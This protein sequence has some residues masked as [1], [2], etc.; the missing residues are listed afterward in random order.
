[1]E[2]KSPTFQLRIRRLTPAVCLY[3]IA[4]IAAII[5]LFDFSLTAYRNMLLLMEIWDPSVVLGA[6]I[7]FTLLGALLVLY[8]GALAVC[9]F[10]GLCKRPGFSALS[11]ILDVCGKIV[12]VLLYVLIVI[13]VG[14]SVLYIL[15]CLQEVMVVYLIMAMVM[16]EGLFGVAF[17][18]IL[19]LLIKFFAGAADVLASLQ[20][21]QTSGYAEYCNT[22]I[23]VCRVLT[24]LG[25]FGIGLAVYLILYPFTGIGCAVSLILTAIANIYL[26]ILLK[27]SQ[28][29]ISH[30]IYQREQERKAQLQSER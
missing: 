10:L 24:L 7:A 12:R 15:Q 19:Q 13:F 5:G 20:F 23:T 17:Y 14:R 6:N 30:V 29:R 18:F 16:F 9:M 27:N 25:L 8:P 3:G 26:S 11:D 22:H 2:Q 1:M 4:A 21:M 28:T